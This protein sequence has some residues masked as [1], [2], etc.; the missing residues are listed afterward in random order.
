M[1]LPIS[2][3]HSHE[4]LRIEHNDRWMGFQ[5]NE[6][7]CWFDEAGFRNATVDCVGETC[8]SKSEGGD[9]SA[10]ISIFVA[11]GDK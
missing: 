3:A 5:R 4:F 1:S 8:N 9:Q 2:D 10:S 7:K 11:S 6:I